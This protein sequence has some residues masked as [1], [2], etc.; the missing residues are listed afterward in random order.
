[1]VGQ[2]GAQQ[3]HAMVARRQNSPGGGLL[4][5]LGSVGGLLLGAT[6]AFLALQEALNRAWNVMPDPDGGVKQPMVKR[7]FSVGMVLGLGFILAVSL[8]ITA[9]ISALGGAVGGGLPTRVMEAVNFVVTLAVLAV[10]FAAMFT[11][12]PDAKVAWRDV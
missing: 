7:L 6:G 4:A 8:A 1:M 5:T 10:L 2:S 3:I 12:L 11:F 9:A